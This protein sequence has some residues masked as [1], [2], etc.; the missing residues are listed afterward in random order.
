MAGPHQY[1]EQYARQP[2][3]LAHREGR[4]SDTPPWASAAAPYVHPAT[5]VFR[6]RSGSF[7]AGLPS[8]LTFLAGVWLASAPF[9][10]DYAHTGWGRPGYWNDVVIG[11]AIAVLAL[12]R[13]VSPREVPWFSVV[14][15][16]LGGWLIAAPFVL[17]YDAGT[18]A[19]RAVANDVVVGIV[20]VLLAGA[21]AAIT[22]RQ[23]HRESTSPGDREPRPR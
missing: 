23:R 3:E 12:V 4:L 11:I 13:T 5:D 1:P 10:L 8:G 21:S 7:G 17:G 22:F 15:V 2:D 9:A 14:N 6:P 16:V 20:V 18:D 19:P